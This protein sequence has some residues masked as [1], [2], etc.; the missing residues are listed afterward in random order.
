M[1]R[2]D[3]AFLYLTAGE[4]IWLIVF[5]ID[6][7]RYAV[8]LHAVER[9]VRAVAVTPLPNTPTVVSGIIDVGGQLLPVFDLRR[10]LGL[11][12]RPISPADHMMIARS[13]Y[14]TL[15]L[16][17]DCVEAV[18]ERDNK[19]LLPTGSVVPGLRHSDGLVRFDDGL[20]LIQDLDRFLSLDE[21]RQLDDA[22]Q[23]VH[24]QVRS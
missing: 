24:R 12:S 5:R 23:I 11:G 15:V 2:R 9:V 10:R 18:I 14:R 7:H 21:E 8:R 13:R 20:V 16:L 4:A 22:L 6:S 17:I 1:D 19:D 3:S